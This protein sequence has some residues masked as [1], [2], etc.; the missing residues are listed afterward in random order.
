M[1]RESA[2]GVLRRILFGKGRPQEPT[3]LVGRRRCRGSRT[4]VA[5][6]T[7]AFSTFA[8]SKGESYLVFRTIPFAFRL[9][10]FPPPIFKGSITV[11]PNSYF[12]SYQ[13]KI[14]ILNLLKKLHHLINLILLIIFCRYRTI[15]CYVL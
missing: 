6:I 12:F 4:H 5:A 11:F 7:E 15:L 14:I 13:V 3:I 1:S 8:V 9:T 2:A 10:Y